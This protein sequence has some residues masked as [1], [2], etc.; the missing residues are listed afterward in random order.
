MQWNLEVWWSIS[1][2]HF[3]L[4]NS[5]KRPDNGRKTQNWL[6]RRKVNGKRMIT[7]HV[8]VTWKNTD[9][10]CIECVTQKF[11]E[12]DNSNVQC[13]S[14]NKEIVGTTTPWSVETWKCEL[15]DPSEA[16]QLNRLMNQYCTWSD[17]KR[18]C[19][20]CAKNINDVKLIWQRI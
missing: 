7:T 16:A 11:V 17:A 9:S 20:T 6:V 1:C 15:G 12:T 2:E 3:L 4:H 14:R 13:D 5:H 18:M 8:R 10:H 19:D